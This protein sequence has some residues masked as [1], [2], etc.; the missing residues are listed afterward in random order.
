MSNVTTD[1]CSAASLAKT[2]ASMPLT[3]AHSGVNVCPV[4]RQAPE[5]IGL[6]HQLGRVK[7]LP[8]QRFRRDLESIWVPSTV[9]RRRQQKSLAPRS[10]RRRPLFG[11]SVF[12]AAVRRSS[13]DEQ[14][15]L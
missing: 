7:Q 5:R 1:R 8:V 12:R 2:S 9:Q 15:G 6:D 14:D 3:S 11:N 4:I 10:L 13:G